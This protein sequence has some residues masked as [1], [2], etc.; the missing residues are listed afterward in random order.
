MFRS[1]GDDSFRDF[2]TACT[3]NQDEILASDSPYVA[4]MDSLD[5]YLRK[6]ITGP[7]IIPDDLVV[8]TL[9]L[10]ARYL[11]MTGFRIGLTGHAAGVFPTL[12]TA[13]ETA[14]YAFLM[15]KDEALSDVWMQRDV[16]PEHLKAC[17][18]AF[19]QPIADARDMIDQ[20]HPNKLGSWMYALYLASI[21]FGAHPN[22]KTVTL[23]TK[24]TDDEMSGMT[25][26][27]SRGLYNIN[28]F[29]YERSLLACVETS[30]AVAIVLSMTQE[31]T[32]EQ[33]NTELNE[34]NQFKNDL[35]EMIHKKFG[36]PVEEAST[37]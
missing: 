32:T 29:E 4:M 12:R 22:A 18:K 21:E 19:K 25:L 8:H 7:E 23:H 36:E 35:E 24:I 33:I 2:M 34:L 5:S 1:N 6:H 14:C 11:L 13:L 28:S 27:E 30:L 16:S 10:N 15:S 3:E 9:R 31:V 20:L 17:K 37:N 26:F